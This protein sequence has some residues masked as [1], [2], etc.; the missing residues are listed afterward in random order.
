[1]SECTEVLSQCHIHVALIGSQFD[2][3]GTVR[4]VRPVSSVGK[5]G[6]SWVQTSAGP[7]LRV[8]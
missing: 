7:T 4:C 2:N 3:E 1:M 6:R 5:S 8:L